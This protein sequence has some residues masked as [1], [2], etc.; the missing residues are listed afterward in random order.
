M[1]HIRPQ[2]VVDTALLLSDY[3]VR[4]ADNAAIAG[5]TVRTIRRWRRLYQRRGLTRGQ[6]YNAAPCPRC[7]GGDLD[8]EVYA[9]LLGW[10]LGDGHISWSGR[11]IP[12]LCVVNDVRYSGLT[13]RVRDLMEGIKKGGRASVRKKGGG[14]LA[15][16]M[17]W[18]HWPCLFP[19][20]GPGPKH[21]RPIVLEPW[22]HEIV[23]Q[24]PG[25]F[26]RGL[27]HSDGCRVMN[28]ATKTENGVTRRWEYPATSS[29]T[30]PPTSAACAAGPSASSVPSTATPPSGTSRWHARRPSRSSTSSSGR[31]PD[32]GEPV[33]CGT[34]ARSP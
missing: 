32:A 6:P 25:R 14:G 22:Q 12:L 2:R 26:L 30:R 20:H 16:S 8:E 11:H 18:R 29:P 24:H 31:S 23:E 1:T 19:Q 3:G 15:I 21:E 17:A 28:W 4:D 27:F 9:E 13:Q 33:S 10:Y 5:V 34:P 7:D